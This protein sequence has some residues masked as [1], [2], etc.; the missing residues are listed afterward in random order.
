MFLFYFFLWFDIK[1]V[2]DT[3]NIWDTKLNTYTWLYILD[4]ISKTSSDG[5]H[6]PLCSGW[7]HPQN[8][9]HSPDSVIPRSHSLPL[10]LGNLPYDK[11]IGVKILVRGHERC[12][13]GFRFNHDG[14]V[15]TLFSRKG[16]PYFNKFGA[17]L[18]VPLSESLKSTK[19]LFPWI[20]KF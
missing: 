8:Y 3:W 11:K 1:A 19:Q 7:D 17:Y 12:E 5:F 14:K 4:V 15:L 2:K 13:N 10:G 18:Q 9:G 16:Y 6:E 20:H